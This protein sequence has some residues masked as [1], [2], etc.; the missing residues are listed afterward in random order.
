ME[1]SLPD[2]EKLIRLAEEALKADPFA[3]QAVAAQAESGAVYCF[4]N[5]AVTAG[6]AEDETAFIKELSEKGDTQISRMVCVWQR[7]LA[8][9][10]PSARFREALLNLDPANC[11]AELLLRTG[12]GCRVMSVEETMPKGK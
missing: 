1:I 6:G 11:G 5:H 8:L 10:V 2:F 7:G 3:D 9:D 12:E 4:A